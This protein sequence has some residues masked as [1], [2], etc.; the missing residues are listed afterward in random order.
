MPQIAGQAL[1]EALEER[2]SREEIAGI[3]RELEAL[4]A[5]A[6][7]MDAQFQKQD[8]RSEQILQA[9]QNFAGRVDEMSRQLAQRP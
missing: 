8:A 2:V 5:H 1:D 7:K 9:I 4:R 6:V 3:W